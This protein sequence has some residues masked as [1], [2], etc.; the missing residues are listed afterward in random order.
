MPRESKIDKKLRKFR[1]EFWPEVPAERLWD[2]KVHKGFSTIPR[3]LSLLIVI[4]NHLTSGSP[5]GTVYLELWC[6][7]R[8]LPVV[9]FESA[10]EHAFHSGYAGQ[11]SVQ[12]WRS[13]LQAL[14]GLGFISIKPGAHGPIS[15]VLL[16]NP[17]QVVKQLN[18][19]GEIPPAL[20]NALVSRAEEIGAKDL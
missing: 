14:E 18:K 8:E 7:I 6:R 2:R 3:T 1:E 19:A 13:K 20:F 10:T 15:Y 9:E 17:H 5:C 16:F 4:I 12:T 11:R